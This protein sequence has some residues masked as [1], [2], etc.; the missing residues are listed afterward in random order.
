MCS[1]DPVSLLDTEDRVC[2]LLWGRLSRKDSRIGVDDPCLVELGDREMLI[3]PRI[4]NL[5]CGTVIDDETQVAN[6]AALSRI[7]GDV[8]INAKTVG[9]G[10]CDLVLAPDGV[11]CGRIPRVERPPAVVGVR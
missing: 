6:R 7:Y 2:D 9:S 3:W 4:F 1:I 10:D 11:L 8:E 5:S